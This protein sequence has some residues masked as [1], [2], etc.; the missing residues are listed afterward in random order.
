MLANSSLLICQGMR[1]YS[2]FFFFKGKKKPS[3]VRIFCPSQNQFALLFPAALRSRRCVPSEN[4]QLRLTS[5]W[6]LVVVLMSEC[7][8]SAVVLPLQ[9][10]LSVLS[11][12]DRYCLPQNSCSAP[13][14]Y[15][16]CNQDTGSKWPSAISLLLPMLAENPWV[17][18]FFL[19]FH[20]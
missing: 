11:Q 12:L 5:A 18:I 10:L 8:C 3:L 4:G 9:P 14:I 19:P 13:L 6:L 1:A 2:A 7:R 17:K 20:R 15:F 16:G